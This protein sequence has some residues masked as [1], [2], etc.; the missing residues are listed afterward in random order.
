MCLST[1]DVNIRPTYK[2]DGYFKGSK[3]MMRKKKKLIVFYMIHSLL[4]NMVRKAGTIKNSEPADVNKQ[5][6]I[7]DIKSFNIENDQSFVAPSVPANTTND[8]YVKY[9]LLPFV[10]A[11]LG[12]TDKSGKASGKD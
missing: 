9:I 4:L 11:M 12:V 5:L 8:E 2:A 10:K 3:I 6:L 7:N 1:S